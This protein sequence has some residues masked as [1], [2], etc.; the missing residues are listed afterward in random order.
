MRDAK[1]RLAGKKPFPRPG[2]HGGAAGPHAKSAWKPGNALYPSPAALVSCQLP[3]GKPNLITIAWCG[4]VN[5]DPPM[6]S[7]SVR[8]SRH[9]YAIIEGTGEF[10]VNIPTVAQA[11]AVDYC[12]VSAAPTRTNSPPPA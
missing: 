2:P 10:V 11:R 9:S 12:G 5:S 6:L 1:Q 3:G 7:I 4:N 8:P